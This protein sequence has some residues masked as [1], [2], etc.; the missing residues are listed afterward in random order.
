M[1]ARASTF[2]RNAFI[3]WPF[4]FVLQIL[5]GCSFFRVGRRSRAVKKPDWRRL[6]VDADTMGRKGQVKELT[7][8]VWPI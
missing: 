4:H 2:A 1:R 7:A 5:L 8:T 3:K 6:V